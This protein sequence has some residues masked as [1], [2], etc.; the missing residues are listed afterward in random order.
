MK[1]VLLKKELKLSILRPISLPAKSL[2]QG[3]EAGS[4]DLPSFSLG[5][6]PVLEA[7]C[8]VGG[9]CLGSSC[10]SFLGM[11]TPTH[12]PEKS[13]HGPSG[14]GCCTQIRASVP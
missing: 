4:E 3:S 11:K 12:D 7:Q 9:S 8:F 13:G 1:S 2:N 5:D 6:T 10:L 14:L